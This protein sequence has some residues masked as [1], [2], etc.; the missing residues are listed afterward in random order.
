MEQSNEMSRFGFPASFLYMSYMSLGTRKPVLRV[1]DL[2]RL[3]LACTA[4]E[5]N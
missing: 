3:K 5:A 1:S 4:T 2:V